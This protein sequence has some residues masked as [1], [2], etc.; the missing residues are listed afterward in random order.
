[1]FLSALL[2]RP[3][4]HNVSSISR[5]GFVARRLLLL[6]LLLRFS[7]PFLPRYLL[8]SLLDSRISL[9]VLL[10]TAANR[11]I[12]RDRGRQARDP[13]ASDLATLLGSPG[14]AFRHR[15]SFGGSRDP[16]PPASTMLASVLPRDAFSRVLIGNVYL[17]SG[18]LLLRLGGV[19]GHE[20]L[21]RSLIT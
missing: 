14:R 15:N 17:G 7:R 20:V 2:R 21:P 8:R 1:M 10:A 5:A 16:R 3:P 18:L 11:L 9:S 6:L 4:R 12:E 13:G 19:S